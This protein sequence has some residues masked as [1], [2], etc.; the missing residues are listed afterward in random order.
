MIITH[1][2]IKQTGEPQII[3]NSIEVPYHWII[4]QLSKKTC[5]QKC[6]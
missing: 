5:D 1:Q 4:I 2:P 6:D 3:T